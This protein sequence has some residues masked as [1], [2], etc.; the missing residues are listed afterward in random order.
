MGPNHRE[1]LLAMDNQN[2]LIPFVTHE[3]EGKFSTPVEFLW[4]DGLDFTSIF[5][6]IIFWDQEIWDLCILLNFDE[7]I[8]TILFDSRRYG[9]LHQNG[10]R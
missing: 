8:I 5:K 10:Y 1:I 2:G 7:I 6:G 4:Q 3:T 9:R